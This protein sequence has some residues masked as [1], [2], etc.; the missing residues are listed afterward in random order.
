MTRVIDGVDRLEEQRS[1]L[2]LSGGG[3]A[4]ST[5]GI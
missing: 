5:F 2:G 1:A 4:G 3:G